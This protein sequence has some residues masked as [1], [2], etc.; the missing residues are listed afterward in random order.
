MN[1]PWF[2]LVP[3]LPN[4]KEIF[5]LSYQHQHQLLDES[6]R[7]SRWMEKEFKG[8]KLNI[9]AIGNIVSQL[10]LHHIS[11]YKN[12]KAWP[13]PVWGAFPATPFVDGLAKERVDRARKSFNIK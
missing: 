6:T 12:D 2:I 13:A 8:D 3:R 4:A 10:H 1:Y 5:Q 11:R 9:A 7:L